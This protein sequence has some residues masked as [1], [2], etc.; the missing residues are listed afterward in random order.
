MCRVAPKEYQIET[1]SHA[2]DIICL[3]DI[4]PQNKWSFLGSDIREAILKPSDP[5]LI[6]DRVLEDLLKDDVYNASEIVLF[7]TDFQ[8]NGITIIISVSGRL[9]KLHDVKLDRRKRW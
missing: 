7:Q 6:T 3:V 8:R 4:F 9:A 2:D 5:A 1:G